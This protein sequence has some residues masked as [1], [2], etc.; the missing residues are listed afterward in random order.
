[1]S[2]NFCPDIVQKLF[3]LTSLLYWHCE[4]IMSLC[5]NKF[6]SSCLNAIIIEVVHNDVDSPYMGG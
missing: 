4:R 3:Q 5:K 2:V 6:P 1:M